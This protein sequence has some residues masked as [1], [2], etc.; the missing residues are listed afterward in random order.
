MAGADPAGS[1]HVARSD[2]GAGRHVGEWPCSSV[3]HRSTTPGRRQGETETAASLSPAAPKRGKKRKKKSATP[4]TPHPPRA[5]SRGD[6]GPTTGPV[7]PAP[8][9][10]PPPSRVSSCRLRQAPHDPCTPVPIIVAPISPSPFARPRKISWP[11][12]VVI[13][14]CVHGWPID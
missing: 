13:S 5:R 14:I 12:H 2:T 1:R 6:G 10:T 3:P 11:P 8:P 7:S 9:T 4:P